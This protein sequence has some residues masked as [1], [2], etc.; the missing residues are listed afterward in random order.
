M[1][2]RLRFIGA[3]LWDGGD[4][5]P[6]RDA[7]FPRAPVRGDFIRLPDETDEW[8]VLRVTM[9][10]DGG[11]GSEPTVDV[12]CGGPYELGDHGTPAEGDDQAGGA[13]M[14]DIREFVEKLH[15]QIGG[16]A[17]EPWQVDFMER[18]Y[19]G[20]RVVLLGSGQSHRAHRR[21]CIDIMAAAAIAAGDSVAFVSTTPQAGEEARQ[22]ALAILDRLDGMLEGDQA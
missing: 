20:E 9:N 17:L 8:E 1:K 21:R 13:W 4:V 18:M 7:P 16:M 22:R 15:E 19:R 14:G 6:Y 11:L 10:F 3:G 5:Y 12:V 2:V